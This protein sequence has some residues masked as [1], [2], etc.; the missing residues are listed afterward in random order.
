M[1]LIVASDEFYPLH[2]FVLA[3]LKRRGH[4]VTPFGSLASKKNESW[5]QVAQEAARQIMAGQFDEGIFFCWTGTGVSIAANKVRGI[6]A[7]LCPDAETAKGA[8][9]WNH[10]NVLCLSN[11]LMTESLVSAILKAWFET[12]FDEREKM[13]VD[14]IE[15]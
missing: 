5:V 2:D 3:D 15:I 1:K 9:L 4:E 11:R 12:A 6:R 14:V 8:R 10:A 13:L 7:A